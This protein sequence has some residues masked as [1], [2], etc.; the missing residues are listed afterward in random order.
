MTATTPLAYTT[1]EEIDQI[2]AE[3]NAGFKSGKTKSIAYRKYQLL[4]LAYL[5]QDN[6]KALEET[7]AKDLG[8][9]PLESVML[10]IGASISE[11]LEAHKHVGK[12]AAPEKPAR[13][14]N[15]MFMNPITYKEPKGVVLIISPFNYPLWLLMVPLAGAIAAGN[16]VVLKPSEA[17]PATAALL[18]EQFP[19][20]I[21]PSLVRVVNGAVPETTKL[22]DLPWGH[23]LYTGSGRVGKIVATAAAKHLTPVSLEL[24]G[25]SPVFIDPASDLK[26]AAKR[27]LW[28]KF[29]NAGQT[30]VAPDYVMV[31]K[32]AQHKFVEELKAVYAEFYPE[33]TESPPRPANT[34][35]LVNSAAW[36]RVYGLLQATKGTVVCGGESGADET[37]KFIPPTIVQDVTF[38]DSLMTEEIFG[39]LLPIVP[40]ESIDAAIAYV[41]SND[42]PL[43]LYVFSQNEAVKQKIFSN[44][45]SGSAV[46]NET[47]LI[48]G[49]S[50][51]PFGGTGGSGYGYH[52]GKYGF[53]MFTHLRAS[54]DTP[55]WIDKLLGVRYPPYTDKNLSFLKKNLGQ[56]LP[57]RPSGP[58]ASSASGTSGARKWFLLAVAVALVGALTKMKNRLGLSAIRGPGA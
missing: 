37:T 36:K 31:P 3:L 40:V 33:T 10:E 19:K 51:L 7:L 24:G 22:L 42:H 26:L 32:E 41:N 44:T 55:S 18:T 57:A 17:C 48:P 47:I 30:C 50:G 21:D 56:K 16:A 5:V 58:P 23:I 38:G 43:A 45:Q 27:V 1:V 46:A 8:R 12:W 28:G 25:K 52:T 11:L 4:Q 35:K 6:A 34:S 13:T 9:P 39:P 53:E 20:Y 29:A 49:I 54:I 15:F 2:H 14:L